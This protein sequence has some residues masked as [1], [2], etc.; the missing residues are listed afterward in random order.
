MPNHL[1]ILIRRLGQAE[2]RSQSNET[3]SAGDQ[4]APA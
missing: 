2:L 1:A 3:R 4:D